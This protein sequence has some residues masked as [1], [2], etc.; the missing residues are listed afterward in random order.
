MYIYIYNYIVYYYTN[1]ITDK[2]IIIELF[3]LRSK[4]ESE[5]EHV[6]RLHLKKVYAQ[7][8]LAIQYS[9]QN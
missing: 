1:Y 4:D 3:E 6:F 9:V 8:S 7:L 2:L 5:N